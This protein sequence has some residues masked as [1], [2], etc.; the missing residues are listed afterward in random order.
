LIQTIAQRART[1]GT[2]LIDGNTATFVWLGSK[3]PALAADFTDWERGDTVRM[4]RTARGVWT[5]SL[6]LPPGA[7][8][9]YA[10]LEGEERLVDPYNPRTTPNGIGDTNHYFYMP[11][12]EPTPL[13]KPN[14]S[15]A[16]GVITKHVLP[17]EGL[18]ASSKRAV[19]FY[20]PA[21]DQPVPLVVVWD[22]KDYL[23]RVRLP[24][25]VDNLIDQ[26]RIHPVALAMIDNGGPARVVEYACSEASLAFLMVSVFPLAQSQ[27]NLLDYKTHPGAG[28][29]RGGAYGVLGAS[30][31]GL[32]A[33]FTALHVP[34]IFGKALC[35]SG[36]YEFWGP[37]DLVFGLARQANPKDFRLWLNVGLYDFRS[38][39]KADRHM[40]TLLTEHGFTFEH[41]Q[42]PA[43]HNYPAWRDEVWRGLEYLFPPTNL[44]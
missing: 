15:A 39:M 6:E 24:V 8:I 37:N 9:E 1:Q 26:K 13:A 22:G 30:M 35:Q 32:M 11:P 43:G 16:H 40:Q 12:G 18:L 33:L 17:T 41:R 2:P 28:E 42:Y 3:A 5:Y 10:F 4:Q 19:W 25:I 44:P 14:R 27:L 34:E 36:A 7:Y 29:P 23:R 20:Q 21:V 31:G 38:L